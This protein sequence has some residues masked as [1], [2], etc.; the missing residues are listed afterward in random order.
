MSGTIQ[1]KSV[2]E[3]FEAQPFAVVGTRCH[4]NISRRRVFNQR[5]RAPATVVFF[6]TVWF[7]TNGVSDSIKFSRRGSSNISTSV[8]RSTEHY[9]AFVRYLQHW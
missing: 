5:G 1:Y 2:Q 6:A 9:S 4:T 3:Y 7:S 8:R